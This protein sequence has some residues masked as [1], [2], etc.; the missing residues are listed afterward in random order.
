MNSINDTTSIYASKNYNDNIKYPFIKIKTRPIKDKKYFIRK[1]NNSDKIINNQIDTLLY[2]GFEGTKQDFNNL[3]GKKE[4]K[5]NLNKLKISKSKVNQTL[6]I[7]PNYMSKTINIKKSLDYSNSAKNNIKDLRKHS[8]INRLKDR[9]K[10]ES[11]ESQRINKN[12]SGFYVGTRNDSSSIL[13]NY[14]N[15]SNKNIS[16]NDRNNTSEKKDKMKKI[17]Q[18]FKI[19]NMKSDEII[20]NGDITNEKSKKE[21]KKIFILNLAKGHNAYKPKKT[22][23]KKV[24][25]NSCK[26][27]DKK[28]I[29]DINKIFN[30][31]LKLKKNDTMKLRKVF[32]PLQTAFKSNLREIQKFTGE[33]RKNVWM[34]RSTANLISFGKAF[35]S[36]SDD[37]FYKNHKDIIGKYP[38][39]Q[40]QANILVLSNKVRDNSILKKLEKN[41]KKIRFISNDNDAIMKE[42]KNMYREFNLVKSRSNP[43]IKL[44]K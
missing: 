39:I 3:Y 26:N 16:L 27:D 34:K 43:L 7:I 28:I 21:K 10:K 30:K 1:I 41:E 9:K 6:T 13:D 38:E 2:T 4:S 5:K 44:K 14:K 11:D 8:L 19:L 22:V 12:Q 18:M 31:Y 37:I 20:A 24:Q 17:K 23:Y 42:I 29:Q 33:D 35:Q 25:S 15:S 36:I 32:D 40:K